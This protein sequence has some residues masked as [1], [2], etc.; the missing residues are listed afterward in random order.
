[1]NDCKAFHSK[2]Q[3]GTTAWIPSRLLDVGS[4][5]GSDDPKLTETA[6]K[7]IAEPY[8]ALSHMW[9]DAKRHPPLQTITSKYESMKSGIPMWQLP[10]TFAHAVA[11]TRQLGLRYIWIDSLCILQD[12]PRD[13]Q[14]E[15]AMM[16]KVY[17]YAEVTIAAY[18]FLSLHEN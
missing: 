16:H 1:M 15:A 2:C 6:Q 11:V 4:P 13:W 8:A 10:K 5:G 17:K 18:V 12:L 3:L 7:C 9:G 14:N